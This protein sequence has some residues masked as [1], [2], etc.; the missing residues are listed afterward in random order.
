M[1]ALKGINGH[2]HTEL[3][4]KFEKVMRGAASYASVRPVVD[5]STQT[6]VDALYQ[7]HSAKVCADILAMMLES[8]AAQPGV[9]P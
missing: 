9:F 6:A 3:D 2:K 1:H 5:P 4:S 7:F 8:L